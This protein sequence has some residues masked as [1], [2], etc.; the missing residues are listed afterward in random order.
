[1]RR[2]LWLILWIHSRGSW[3]NLG[4]R[5]WKLFLHGHE[6][7]ESLEITVVSQ[8]IYVTGWHNQLGGVGIRKIITKSLHMDKINRSTFLPEY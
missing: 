4:T 1:M 5:I 3:V 8:K 6:S 7:P 2:Q